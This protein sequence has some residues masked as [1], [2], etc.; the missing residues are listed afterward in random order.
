LI[1]FYC[2]I[3]IFRGA[4]CQHASL[5]AV[6]LNTGEGDVSRQAPGQLTGSCVEG[7][8]EQTHILPSCTG[9]TSLN[10]PFCSC[11]KH[12][13]KVTK[14]NSSMKSGDTWDGEED[15]PSVGCL[16]YGIILRSSW[17]FC[18][19]SIRNRNHCRLQTL[20]ATG[21]PG[22]CQHLPGAHIC[23]PNH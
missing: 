4:L 5:T 14:P 22:S 23:T 15:T 12:M 18:T 6:E 3:H 9:V 1:N 21:C 10:L 17:Y 8:K 16:G 19:F 13:H 11:L 7:R 20:L 2:S